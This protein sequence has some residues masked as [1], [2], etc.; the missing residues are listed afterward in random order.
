[1]IVKL[2]LVSRNGKVFDSI[3]VVVDRYTKI[4]VYIPYNELID[5]SKLVDLFIEHI[6]YRFSALDSIVSDRG[7]LFTSRF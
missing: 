2:P 1:M 5:T 4:V 3:L 7:L 6:I